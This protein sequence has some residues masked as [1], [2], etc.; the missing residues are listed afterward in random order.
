MLTGDGGYLFVDAG[1]DVVRKVSAGGTITKVA[2]VGEM[3]SGCDPLGNGGP[4]LSAHLDD[5]MGIAPFGSSGFIVADANAGQLR[6]VVDGKID[7]VGV[8][9]Y[10]LDVALLGDGSYLFALVKPAAQ[11]SALPTTGSIKRLATDGTI[12]TVADNLSGAPLGM[13]VTARGEILVSTTDHKI[14]RISYVPA[15]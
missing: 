2:G 11:G 12:T 8:G 9:Y 6:Y 5:P 4:A 10:P 7:G 13:T 14:Q 3:C 1:F 15:N